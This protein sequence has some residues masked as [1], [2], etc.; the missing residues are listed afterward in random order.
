MPT[1]AAYPDR[2][3]GGYTLVEVL[4][5]AAVFALGV[6][7]LTP[8]IISQVRATDAAGART[9]AVALAQ[10]KLEGFRALPYDDPDPAREDVVGLAA[11]S[12][13]LAPPNH[14]YTR[15]WRVTDAPDTSEI[16]RIA[17]AVE[18]QLPGRPPGRVVLVTSR[19]RY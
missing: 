13:V 2:R 7:A 14:L 3:P 5:A 11:G 10:A 6:A 12:E 18:W 17:V 16:K 8:L 4:V 19:S 15:S 1:A 9:Q